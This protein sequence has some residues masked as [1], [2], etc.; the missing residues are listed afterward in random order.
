MWF[1]FPQSRRAWAKRHD[2][3]LRHRGLRSGEAVFSRLD[4]WTPLAPGVNLMIRHKDKLA[5]EIL[6]Y[7]DDVK[8]RSC[9]T[10][11]S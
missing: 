4:T 1:I 11:F 10:L 7:P 8:F 3:A 6:G 2:A 9:L 5:F